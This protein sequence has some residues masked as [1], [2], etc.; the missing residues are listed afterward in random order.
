MAVKFPLGVGIVN[1]PYSEWSAAIPPTV[2]PE[3]ADANK[4]VTTG[5]AGGGD[6]SIGSPW[7]LAEAMTQAVSTDK[8]GIAAGV[9]V[10]VDPGVAPANYHFTP[11][12][13]PTNSG[14]A[15]DPIWF[16]GQDGCDVRSGATV[17]GSGWPAYGVLT[18]DYV[19]FTNIISD[20]TELNNKQAL[21]SAPCVLRTG[22]GLQVHQGVFTGESGQANNFSGVRLE[23]C[24][25]SEVADN[26]ISG[27]IGGTNK[28]GVIVYKSSNPKI[29]HNDI[30]NCNHGI[31]IKG[32]VTDAPV[33]DIW[34][35]DVYQN[36]IYDVTECFRFHGPVLGPA[37]ELSLVYQNIC[38][39]YVELAEFTSSNTHVGEQ[40]GLRIFNNS[41]FGGTDGQWRINHNYQTDGTVPRDNIFFNNIHRT[42]VS[43]L[44]ATY[45]T[46]STNDYF[47]KFASYETNCISA[48]TPFATGSGGSE[49]SSLSLAT[50]QGTYTQ[51]V[52]SVTTDP[53]YTNEGL[54]VEDFHLQVGS[55]SLTA[56]IDKLGKF[57]AIDAVIP[58]GAYITGSEVIG[59]RP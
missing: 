6:G 12:F 49:L 43:Y 17:S 59:V 56:G 7:T 54:G 33:N 39:D 40:D 28:A 29:H 38:Y 3:Y 4:Y 47:D 30:S 27:F 11:A 45:G 37:N 8:V 20:V 32:S 22:T 24:I 26:A 50:W 9:Y 53:L 21:D 58:Q 48:I 1:V 13:R 19:G 18:K 35:L 42:G 57:G 23:L 14:T 2:V 34:G 10:G 44:R 41:T 15:S 36:K 52:N 51:D 16:I 46:A 31:Q 55:P 5:A 25:S